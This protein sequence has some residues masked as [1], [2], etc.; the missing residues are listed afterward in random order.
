MAIGREE[1]IKEN[2]VNKKNIILTCLGLLLIAGCGGPTP[3]EIGEI[4]LCLSIGIVFLSWPIIVFLAWLTKRKNLATDGKVGIQYLLFFIA[5]II[6]LIIF[7]FSL[8]DFSVLFV[9]PILAVPYLL[10]F[11]LIFLFLPRR[12]LS[13]LPLFVLAPHF[14]MSALLYAT[15]Q[16]SLECLLP[17]IFV[18]LFWFLTIPV[19][20]ILFI[21][22][23]LRRREEVSGDTSKGNNIDLSKET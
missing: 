19:G 9:G 4:G 14:V 16:E 12:F 13:Y 7:R 21:V 10:F 6:I 8:G 15:N 20:V 23:L 17:I 1:L 18:I 5:S 2:M 22:L 3:S 11:T